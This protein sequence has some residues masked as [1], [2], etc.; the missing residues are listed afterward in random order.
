[1]SSTCVH[2]PGLIAELRQQVVQIQRPPL[3]KEQKYLSMTDMQCALRS[4]DT[5]PVVLQHPEACSRT[6]EEGGERRLRGVPADNSP[7]VRRSSSM[8][9]AANASDGGGG[10]AV[11][12]SAVA[13]CSGD[14][15]CFGAGAGDSGVGGG[16]S[17]GG[18]AGHGGGSSAAIGNLRTTSRAAP[19]MQ[20]RER[21]NELESGT[22]SFRRRQAAGAGAGSCGVIGTCSSSSS[23]SSRSSSVAGSPE[24]RA[25]GAGA[26]FP[27]PAG[28]R[29]RP[30]PASPLLPME[31][32]VVVPA[33][34]A[35]GEI[36]AVAPSTTGCQTVTAAASV[37]VMNGTVGGSGRGGLATGNTAVAAVT[38]STPLGTPRTTMLRLLH[39]PVRTSAGSCNTNGWGG[40]SVGDAGDTGNGSRNAGSVVDG[41]TVMAGHSPSTSLRPPATAPA[42]AAAAPAKTPKKVLMLWEKIQGLCGMQRYP[43]AYSEALREPDERC[44]LWLVELT[45]PIPERLSA[46]ASTRLAKRLVGLLTQLSAAQ[47][48]KSQSVMAMLAW[49]SCTVANF[50]TS[51]VQELCDVL[52]PLSGADSPLPAPARVEA[53][54]LFTRATKL[55]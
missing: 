31:S 28:P 2:V 12:S 35:P 19:R 23:S 21:S 49:I 54:L 11:P 24:M 43:E 20:P 3:S 38:A 18:G 1:M 41:S 29:P 55:C 50:S 48:T 13:N 30:A 53:L 52:R 6:S 17:L 15:P 33:P 40:G 26:T 36:R 47:E 45:G 14:F 10:R 5:S 32:T 4:G 27:L 39:R 44:L 9:C 37:A 46:D 25:A 34:P 51:Q 7:A 16:G 22:A 8:L 42:A